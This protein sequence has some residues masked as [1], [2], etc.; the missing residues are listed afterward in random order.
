MSEPAGGDPACW[1]HLG[2][3]GPRPLTAAEVGDLLARD[4][5]AHLATVDAAGFPHVTPIW[6]LWDGDAVLLSSRPDRPHVARLQADPRA[7]LVVDDEGPEAPGGRR[8]N[9]QVRMAGTV[10]VGEDTGGAVT[11]AI[12]RKYLGGAAKLP[13]GPRVVLRLEP[14]TVV[15]LAG[16]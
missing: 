14:T 10:A 6:F 11:A 7:A 8:P 1:A 15:A 16:F 9:R 5:V 13:V 4:L 2:L 12:G 3:D